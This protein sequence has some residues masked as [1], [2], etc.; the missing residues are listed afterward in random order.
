MIEP[1][2]TDCEPNGI[3]RKATRKISAKIQVCD[4]HWRER[5]SQPPVIT[6]RPNAPQVDGPMEFKQMP[7]E[8]INM[9]S[10]EITVPAPKKKEGI[11]TMAEK[12][13]CGRDKGHTGRHVGSKNGES[14]NAPE[15]NAV[16][17]AGP[18]RP[19][20]ARQISP[21]KLGEIDEDR[22]NRI[23]NCLNLAAKVR[24]IGLL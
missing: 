5:Y 4:S 10:G 2:C 8:V 24:V 15:V 19:A 22:A 13:F 3:I 23:W 14:R 9:G 21:V 16:R 12:C 17:F 18:S 20:L 7:A 11:P 6:S 1:N